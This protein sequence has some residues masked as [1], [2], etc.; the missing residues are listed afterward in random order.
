L[1]I[2][3]KYI[4]SII[5]AQNAFYDYE[6]V[7]I[8]DKFILK[9]IDDILFCQPNNKT[10]PVN[11]KEALKNFKPSKKGLNLDTLN[12]DK[13][14]VILIF[15]MFLFLNVYFIA[16]II[17]YKNEMNK[18]AHKKEELKKYNL[19]LTLI[20][21]NAI[22][23]KLKKTDL[24]QQR[25]R[26]DLEFFSKTPLKPNEEYR[27]LALKNGIYKVNIKTSQNL[28]GFFSKRFE[29]KSEE[30]NKTFYKAELSHE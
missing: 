1:K 26:K 17:N 8:N 20:Q 13:T 14:S 21:L 15:L 24:S 30:F 5:P 22:Y 27:L 10:C 19:P 28:H 25:I 23:S 3:K 16:G 18:L 12:L 29:I 7:E 11:I 4:N 9:K 2:D 6:C